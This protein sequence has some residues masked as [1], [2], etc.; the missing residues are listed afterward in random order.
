MLESAIKFQT[1][2]D[3]SEEQ[4]NK[5]KSKLL[6]SKGVPIKEDWNYAK[7][8][9]PFL[10]GF[11]NSTLRISGSLYVTSNMYFHEVFGLRKMIRKMMK[12]E[13]ES[14]RKMA[15]KMIQKYDKYWSNIDNINI[16]L[17]I[18][19]ILDPRH[20]LGYVTFIIRS[21]F[22]TGKAEELIDKIDIVLDRLFNHY[23]AIVGVVSEKNGS[24]SQAVDEN[25]CVELDD[26][27]TAFLNNQ[28]KRQL[29]ESSGFTGA[30][31][32]KDKYFDEACEPLHSKFEILTWWKKNKARFPVMAAMA[33]D[34]LA[35]PASTV[36][37]ESAFSTGG[38]VLDAFRSSL[39]PRLVEA[40]ICSQNWLRSKSFPVDIE[41]KLEELEALE[42]GIFYFYSLKLTT[43]LQVL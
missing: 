30:K 34:I 16:Y 2:F 37:S 17:F 32:E 40:L 41:E 20:K 25:E 22:D 7:S 10:R 39:T 24:S 6:S 21:S 28:Y 27:P 14:L 11:Y 5:Y 4:D 42:A 29:E 23:S 35:I 33:R 8:L 3:M 13:D 19:P 15:A 26:D 12:D 1:P 9:S 43:L 31:S 18:G 36:A 38:R